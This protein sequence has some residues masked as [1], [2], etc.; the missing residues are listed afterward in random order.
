MIIDSTDRKYQVVLTA[1]K[2]TNDMPVIVNWEPVSRMPNLTPQLART[3]TNGI[4][5]VDILATTD[6]PKSIKEI[7]I[8]NNDTASKTVQVF[9]SDSGTSFLIVNATLQPGETLGYSELVQWYAQDASGNRKTIAAATLTNLADTINA[10][11]TK[12]TPVTADEFSYW[13]SVSLALRK[14]TWGNIVTTLGSTFAALAGSASQVFSVATATAAG[15][16]VPLSQ[17]QTITNPTLTLSG[18]TGNPTTPVTTTA[19]VST[20]G[21]EV[22]VT[23]VFSN[24]DTT[25]ASGNLRVTGL[26]VATSS[27]LI[28]QGSVTISGF[29]TNPA[30]CFVSGTSLYIYNQVT[31]GE[32]PMVAG[33]SKYLLVQVTYFTA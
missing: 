24:V 10:A 31:F 20:S 28:F 9:L 32:I 15:H 26:P 13:D 19:F 1:A 27:N 17:F 18:S 33:A 25:G 5:A 11:T 3:N 22:T 29:G 7:T 8:Y 12:A 4:T 21:R 23:A 14:C 30:T 2:T 6:L 16:A